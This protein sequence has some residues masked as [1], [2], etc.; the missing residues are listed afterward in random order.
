MTE[1]EGSD[2]IN[3]QSQVNMCESEKCSANIK[4]TH[5]AS[6]VAQ[7]KPAHQCESVKG[8]FCPLMHPAY[9]VGPR[10]GQAAALRKAAPTDD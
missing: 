6:Q 5:C 4:L 9:Q 3:N 7:R 8:P 1:S 2:N 10:L